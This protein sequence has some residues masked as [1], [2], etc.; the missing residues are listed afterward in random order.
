LTPSGMIERLWKPLRLPY[1]RTI[2]PSAIL[3][4]SAFV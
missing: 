4:A 2:I 1:G 3:C